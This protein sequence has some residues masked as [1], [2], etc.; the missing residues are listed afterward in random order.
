MS[1]SNLSA[2]PSDHAPSAQQLQTTN[3]FLNCHIRQWG[4]SFIQCVQVLVIICL[5]HLSKKMG[6]KTPSGT[7]SLLM[8]GATVCC[9]P[10]W[11]P[12]NLWTTG[13]VGQFLLSVHCV[14]FGSVLSTV[15]LSIYAEMSTFA[16]ECA[17]ESNSK[18][19][20][21]MCWFVRF[22]SCSHNAKHTSIQLGT[23][24]TQHLLT[25]RFKCKQCLPCC[26][27]LSLIGMDWSVQLKMDISMNV[28]FKEVTQK[29]SQLNERHLPLVP[30][31]IK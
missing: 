20:S 31:Y 12:V 1:T 18:I 15:S 26:F 13:T 23:H 7:E 2:H 29:S 5:F 22:I 19:I 28:Q 8:W 24:Q 3:T 6:M 4:P 10:P 9:N 25:Q 27:S 30:Y 14:K 16:D 17:S 21:A 11:P